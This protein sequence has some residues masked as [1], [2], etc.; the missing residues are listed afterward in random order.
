[1][2]FFHIADVH[3]GMQPDKGC[4]WSED[5]RREIWESFKKVIQQAGRENASLFLIAGDLFHRQPLLKELKEVNALF[6]SIPNTKIVLIAGNHDYIKEN[7]FYRKISWAKNVFWLSKEE[8]S[9]VDF[10]D[11]G[12]RVYGFSYHSREILAARYNQMQ[13]SSPM[14]V[15]ILLAHGGDET[16]IPIS[17]DTFLYTPFDYVALGHIHKPQVLQKNKA[18]YAG[19][20]EPLDKNETGAHG[21]IK[22]EIRKKEIYTEFVPSSTREYRTISVQVGKDTTQ[23]S[24]ENAIRKAIGEQGEEY[25]YTILLEGKK[26]AHTEFFTD[27]FY[28]LG[29]IREVE[30]KTTMAYSKE[31]LKENYK[32]SIME[33]YLA[34]F[35]Q[36]ELTEEMEKAFQYGVEALLESGEELL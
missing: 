33:A 9:H 28:K 14:P 34:L 22:G 21:Y 12:V 8:L 24:L 23:F 26:P 16:H 35:E 6:A 36:E 17:G 19:S 18:I 2:R 5:R 30:D 13:I 3:L 20:L 31:Q 4:P 27:A 10:P 11:L 29:N 32:G 7:S 1:M 25:L 15:N